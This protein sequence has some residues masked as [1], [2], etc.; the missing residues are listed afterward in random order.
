MLQTLQSA[1]AQE[2]LLFS[3]WN[4]ATGERA[5]VGGYAE[6]P[7]YPLVTLSEL[8]PT[9]VT[10]ITSDY[11]SFFYHAQVAAPNLFPAG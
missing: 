6:A 2:L 9:G 1:V 7:N 10:A 8:A 4:A 5:G 3:A 11:G